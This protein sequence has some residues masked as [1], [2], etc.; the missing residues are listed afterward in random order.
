MPDGGCWGLARMQLA[1]Q[2]KQEGKSAHPLLSATEKT[3]RW[4]FRLKYN[5]IPA[6]HPRLTELI[7]DKFASSKN[8]EQTT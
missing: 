1:A 3:M 4:D 7:L 6:Y 2:G 8:N 5:S